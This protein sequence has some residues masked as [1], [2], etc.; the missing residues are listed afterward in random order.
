MNGSNG[1][2]RDVEKWVLRGAIGVLVAISAYVVIEVRTD[3]RELQIQESEHEIE[4]RLL[5]YDLDA[6]KTMVRLQRQIP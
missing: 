2:T 3:I 6:I 1:A 5:K 4:L